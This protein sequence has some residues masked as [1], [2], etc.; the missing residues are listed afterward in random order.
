MFVGWED[1][2]DLAT[3][4]WAYTVFDNDRHEGTVSH[5]HGG[6]VEQDD[7]DGEGL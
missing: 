1:R 6:V 4:F 7:Q 5:T 3:K 2:W